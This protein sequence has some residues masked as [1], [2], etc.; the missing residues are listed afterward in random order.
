MQYGLIQA[1]G[2]FGRPIIN[3]LVRASF[4]VTAISRRDS[5]NNKNNND[6]FAPQGVAVVKVDYDAPDELAQALAGHDAAVCVFGG[7]AI[8]QGRPNAIVDA[9]LRCDPTVKRLVVDDFGWGPVAHRL[10]EFAPLHAR[11]KAQWEYAQARAEEAGG[12]VLTWTGIAIGNPIDWVK[13]KKDTLFMFIVTEGSCLPPLP[14]HQALKKF[15]LMGF[16][17]ANQ[18]ATIY[19]DGREGFTGTTLEGIGQSVVGVLQHLDETANRF[20]KVM[21]IMTCQKDLLQAFNKA[22]GRAWDVRR[23]TTQALLER[24]REKLR[25]GDKGWM[26]DLAVAQLYDVGQRWCVVAPFREESDSDM[27]GVVAETPDQIVRKVLGSC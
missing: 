1:S 10:P 22:S 15:P 6:D 25:E 14:L 4:Q 7:A 20:V 16:D 23:S 24:G 11:R 9:A 26:L 8:A 27:L 18:T 13:K 12:G 17:T 5:P 21:S 3:A 2:N 19:D